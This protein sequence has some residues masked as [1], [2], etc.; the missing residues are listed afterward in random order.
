M[1]QAGSMVLNGKNK[2]KQSKKI[3]WDGLAFTSGE[4]NRNR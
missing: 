1:V 4:D 3:N 2:T